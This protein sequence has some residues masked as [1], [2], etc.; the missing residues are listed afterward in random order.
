MSITSALNAAK[1]GLQI[2]GLRADI[3][4]TNVAN[5][6]TPGFVRRAVNIGE[7]LIGGQTA[8]VLSNGISRS[9][10]DVLTRERLTLSSDLAQSNILSSA[11]QSIRGQLGDSLD[12]TGLFQNFSDFETALSN[13]AATPESSANLTALFNAADGIA[14]EFNTLSRDLA[15]LRSETDREI[16]LGVDTVN[17]ALSQVQEL[18]TQ[19]AST[20]PNTNKAAALQ[21]ERQRQLNTIAEYLPIQ[22]V[23]RDSGT[24][25]ILTKEGV[26]LLASDART[27]EFSQSFAFG[28]DQTLDN[29]LL[30][31]LTVDGTDITPG[32]PTFAA[33]S[34]GALGALFQLRDQDIPRFSDQLDTLANDLIARLSDDSIDPA[35]TPGGAGLFVDPDIAAGVGSAGRISINAAVDPSAGGSLTRLRDG[36]E[37]TGVGPPGNNTILSNLLSAT[38]SVQSINVNG[39]QGNFSA[40]E[41]AA[42]LSSIVGQ[43]SVNHEAVQSS[44]LAQHAALQEAERSETGVDVDTQLQE[45][46]LVEQAYA[47]NA[48]VIEVAN[49]LL[50]RLL[51]I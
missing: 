20:S 4:A 26:F 35:S 5:A 30:S 39:L 17:Q 25:D 1:S 46:L 34:S 21:D 24:I 50:N 6:S 44:T 38:T 10:S 12:G 3:V 36:L 43:T 8:G 2:T 41:L 33:I 19:I 48:R 27:I 45:L 14:Q 16:V 29:G 51:E 18:N 22:T 23:P 28:P 49:Q 32:A 13:A 42:H 37:A 47:A 40:P 11:W 7:N 31:G 15:A 9:G